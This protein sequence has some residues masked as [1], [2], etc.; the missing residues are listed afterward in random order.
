MATCAPHGRR[1][2]GPALALAILLVLGLAALAL[3]APQ[4]VEQAAGGDCRACHGGEAVLPKDHPP[5]LGQKAD[6]CAKCHG[7]PG[8]KT[9][10]GRLSLAHGHALNGVACGD[11]HGAAREAVAQEKCLECHGPSDQLV[12]RSEGVKP[13]PHNSHY[14]PDMACDLCHKA[15]AKSEDYCAQCHDFKLIVP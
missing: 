8:G 10:R 12:K 7:G 15:H 3:A 2:P 9:L 4:R 1:T 6:D 11:C 5:T 13:N 14:G